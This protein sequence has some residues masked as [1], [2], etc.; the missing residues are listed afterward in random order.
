[1]TPRS[2]RGGGC[3]NIL[4]GGGFGDPH[5]GPP[6]PKPPIS[7]TGRCRERGNVQSWRLRIS[8]VIRRGWVGPRGALV[9]TARA[10][11]CSW[12]VHPAVLAL[13]VGREI[14]G[15]KT[16]TGA[17]LSPGAASMWFC[18]SLIHYWPFLNIHS[19]FSCGFHV[20]LPMLPFLAEPQLLLISLLLFPG[21]QAGCEA[22]RGTDVDG[23]RVG[24]RQPCR[25]PAAM[26][27]L[28]LPLPRAR[29]QRRQKNSLA[30]T[31]GWGDLP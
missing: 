13:A 12:T 23:R 26:L 27:T 25:D 4:L 10:I 11:L 31:K 16:R 9:Q 28:P 30:G 14:L 19:V 3:D 18:S 7:V 21:P 1:M 29:G 15:G 24:T 6:C 5:P 8:E 20:F 17:G 2:W 22:A